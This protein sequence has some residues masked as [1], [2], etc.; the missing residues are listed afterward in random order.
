MTEF[1]LIR[2]DSPLIVSVPH[3]GTEL[4]PGFAERLSEA[5]QP[6]SDTDWHLPR[7]YDFVHE[8]GATMLAARYSRYLIDLNRPPGGESLY[9]GQTTTGL[10]PDLLFD[11][12]PI[13]RSGA[14]PD[15]AEIAARLETWWRP[16]HAALAAEIARVKAVHGFALVYDAHSIKG[17]LPRLFDGRLPDLNLGTARGASVTPAL[18]QRLAEAVGAAASAGFSS[19]V[20]GRFVGGYITRHYGRPAESVLAMQLEMVQA[21]YMDEDGP[22]FDYR[23]ERADK[24]RPVLKRL[25]ETFASWRPLKE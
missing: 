1:S 9:P 14:E 17:V 2:G 8:L 19:V 6:L 5:A 22:P 7:L 24:V 15:S 25:V 3:C 13:Y 10:C 18:R 11:G 21:S 16:Y 23:P 20:D 12:R 4:P